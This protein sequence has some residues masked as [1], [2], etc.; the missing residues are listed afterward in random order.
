MRQADLP[1]GTDPPGG[2]MATGGSNGQTALVTGVTA[3]IDPMAHLVQQG[4]DDPGAGAT[5]A[6]PA[7]A[8]SSAKASLPAGKPSER[9]GTVGAP[10]RPPSRNRSGS[11][12]SSGL[13]YSASSIADRVRTRWSRAQRKRRIFSGYCH[14]RHRVPGQSRCR[15]RHA[16]VDGPDCGR[17]ATKTP[18]LL[19]PPGH[20]RASVT[21]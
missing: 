19:K 6:P 20:H 11:H 7:C 1:R 9:H 5:A 2:R 3:G 21:R 12:H 18:E 13:R 4:G 16:D 14:S 10:W 8:P 15:Q 17:G